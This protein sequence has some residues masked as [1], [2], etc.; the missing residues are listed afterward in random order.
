[1]C[2]KDSQSFRFGQT[3]DKTYKVLARDFQKKQHAKTLKV[4]SLDPGNKKGERSLILLNFLIPYFLFSLSYLTAPI[5][6][7]MLNVAC[8]TARKRALSIRRP[9]TRQIP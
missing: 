7:S 4:E 6:A 2:Y 1:M 5:F 9:V 8:G 3:F